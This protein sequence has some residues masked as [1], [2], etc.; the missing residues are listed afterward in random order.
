MSKL[1]ESKYTW[2]KIPDD[3]P[4]KNLVFV[5]AKT[6]T[7]TH[8]SDDPVYTHRLFDE[9]ELKE[10]A[11]SLARRQI[12][13]NHI[14]EMVL[15]KPY[16]V[17]DAQ[18]NPE[19]KSV[20]ALLYLPD[21][22]IQKIKEG[23]IKHVSVE[24]YWRDEEHLPE[25]VKFKGLVFDR[26]D[27]LEGMNPGDKNTEIKLLE[28][29]KALMEGELEIMDEVKLY[30][31]EAQ[32]Y[33]EL[34]SLEEIIVTSF[35]K[36]GEPLGPYKDFD[37]CVASVK[38][39]KGLSD[40]RARK[41]CGYLY[42]K[43]EKKR[44]D[45]GEEAKVDVPETGD[46]VHVRVKDPDSF[47]NES[48]R[49]IDIT[50]GIKAVVGCPKGHFKGGKCE[51]G[52]EVQKFVFDKDKYTSE[53]AKKW[54]E[55]H[56][57]E[58][59]ELPKDTVAATA[60]EPA[61]PV[62]VEPKEKQ[63]PEIPSNPQNVGPMQSPKTPE[64]VEEEKKVMLGKSMN[65]N[66]DTS[67]LIPPP[68]VPPTEPKLAPTVGPNLPKLNPLP[69]SPPNLPASMIEAKKKE[70]T[71]EQKPQE[72]KV[73]QKPV[74]QKVEQKVEPKPEDKIKELQ[75]AVDK[76]QKSLKETQESVDKKIKEA[77]EK[78]RKE[79]QDKIKEQLKR[80]LISGVYAKNK[81]VEVE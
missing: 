44:K 41:Y 43:I 17:I 1:I 5:T 16:Q 73:E 14:P 64:Q 26:V 32:Q 75:E 77:I 37:D 53:Q 46:Y 40:E 49:Y 54:V 47:D 55:E 65:P 52:T 42:W 76:L 4:R 12:G 8:H 11:R 81:L 69:S 30:E 70:S 9:E 61:T 10:S 27:L 74:E 78:T 22:Y 21:E 56:K 63:I 71:T 57:K 68:S 34:P 28:S 50:K 67:T 80:K 72:Q 20:E 15:P 19:T 79:E 62:H 33:S 48:F 31:S 13:I 66:P 3:I 35:R 60:Q 38:R 6:T 18:Y 51:V 2:A 36:L 25:G 39:E 7:P 58:A 59:I 45:V 29:K 24:Y 23:K